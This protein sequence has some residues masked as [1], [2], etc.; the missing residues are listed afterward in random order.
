M[1][2][3]VLICRLADNNI[4][5]IQ[6]LSGVSRELIR[7]PMHN[8]LWTNTSV[9]NRR[10]DCLL[11]TQHMTQPMLSF[12]NPI[13]M[14]TIPE[15]AHFTAAQ[16]FSNNCLLQFKAITGLGKSPASPPSQTLHICAHAYK[17]HIQIHIQPFMDEWFAVHATNNKMQNFMLFALYWEGWCIDPHKRMLTTESCDEPVKRNLSNYSEICRMSMLQ[18]H[19]MWTMQS[20]ALDKDPPSASNRVLSTSSVK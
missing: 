20:I 14:E 15:T 18:N 5:K 11:S 10:F 8:S 6:S 13:D 3:P 4:N 19:S 17:Q 16:S 2:K 12:V 7:N 1:T 9:L